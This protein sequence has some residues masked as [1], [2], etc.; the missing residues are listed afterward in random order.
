L[1]DRLASEMLGRRGVDAV[2]DDPV[3]G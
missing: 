3:V 2:L 1:S